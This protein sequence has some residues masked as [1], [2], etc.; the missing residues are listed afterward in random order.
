MHNDE[1]IIGYTTQ[2]ITWRTN[3]TCN[4]VNFPNKDVRTFGFNVVPIISKNKHDY[5]NK[6]KILEIEK[7][8]FIMVIAVQ[9]R[10]II[11]KNHFYL[12]QFL[13]NLLLVIV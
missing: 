7:E 3:I 5:I 1:L 6:L 4:I 13:Y 11:I 12:Q 10:M 8:R 2:T 9:V